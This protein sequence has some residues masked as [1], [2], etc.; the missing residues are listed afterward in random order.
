ML[1]FR[2][3]IYY[4]VLDIDKDESFPW[5]MYSVHNSYA[6][7]AFTAK[8]HETLEE[9]IGCKMKGKKGKILP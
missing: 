5:T 3:S 2:F 8:M 1:C 4:F 7:H 9:K 6:S